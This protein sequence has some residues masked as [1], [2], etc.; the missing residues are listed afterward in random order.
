[1]DGL[2]CKHIG[3]ERGTRELGCADRITAAEDELI[4]AVP[5]AVPRVGQE[6]VAR[7]E[8]HAQPLERLG[9]DSLDV[10]GEAA[11]VNASWRIHPQLHPEGRNTECLLIEVVKRA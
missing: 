6:L 10:E 5:V 1:M 4:E 3:D 8:V 11:A 7:V 9:H 2:F